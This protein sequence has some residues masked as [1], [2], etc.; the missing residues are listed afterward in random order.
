MGACMSCLDADEYVNLNYP[1]GKTIDH[2]PGLSLFCC[3][4]ATKHKYPILTSEDYIKV[5]HLNPDQNGNLVE[6]IQGPTLYRPNDAYSTISAKQKKTKLAQDEYLIVKDVNG[7]INV[8]SGPILYCPQP[9]EELSAV[10]KKINLSATQ[11]IFVTTVTTGQIRMETGPQ[12]YTPQSMEEM[13]NVRQ[14]IVLK[15]C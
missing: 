14:K 11:Y 3:A 9:Y 15:N 4:S 6:I 12:L 1:R 2:G 7:Q 5:T 8:I 13:T 10:R